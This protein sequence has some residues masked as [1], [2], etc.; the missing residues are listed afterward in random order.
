VHGDR[1]NAA[2]LSKVVTTPQP[3]D[4][5][6]AP[7]IRVLLDARVATLIAWPTPELFASKLVNQLYF[8]GMAITVIGWGFGFILLTNDRL[9]EDLTAAEQHTAKL[10]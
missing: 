2:E 9:I 7:H 5:A 10:N 8:G 6:T 1:A 3:I 4:S